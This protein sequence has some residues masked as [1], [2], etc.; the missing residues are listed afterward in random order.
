L[1]HFGLYQ[2]LF[3]SYFWFLSL[4]VW[5]HEHL[6]LEPHRR[7]SQVSCSIISYR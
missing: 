7:D 5:Y 1:T 6:V 3:K 4:I 2:N